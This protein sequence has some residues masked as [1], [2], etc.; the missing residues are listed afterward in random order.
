M[1]NSTKPFLKIYK[2]QIAFWIVEDAKSAHKNVLQNLKISVP[3]TGTNIP[4]Y[5]E[6]FIRPSQVWCSFRI[7]ISEHFVFV[8]V[9][10][11]I[12]RH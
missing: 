7:I 6:I 2:F 3:V 1:F 9:L 11:N 5:L 4:E 12:K 10:R 8:N